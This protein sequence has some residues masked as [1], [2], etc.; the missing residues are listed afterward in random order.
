M[1]TSALS[2]IS[3]LSLNW[4]NYKKAI[5]ILQ[6]RYRR[7]QVLLSVH[8]TKFVQLPKTKPSS[9]VKG[10]QNMYGQIGIS[11]QNLKSLDIDITTYGS[12]LVPLLNDKLLSEHR[13]IL[14]RKLENDL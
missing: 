2:A 4:A 9:G 5:D 12:L 6:Q 13:V 10:L 14:S 7:T 1:S 3:G 11:V 8:M